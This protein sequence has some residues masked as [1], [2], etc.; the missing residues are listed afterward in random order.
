[1]TVVWLHCGSSCVSDQWLMLSILLRWWAIILPLRTDNLWPQKRLPYMDEWFKTYKNLSSVDER[2]KKCEKPCLWFNSFL[3][4]P[5]QPVFRRVHRFWCY[6]NVL[7][8]YLQCGLGKSVLQY[9]CF[10]KS[11]H[12]SVSLIFCDL[13]KCSLDNCCRSSVSALLCSFCPEF[14]VRN[15]REIILGMYSVIGWVVLIFVIRAFCDYCFIL[16]CW[17]HSL[18][19]LAWELCKRLTHSSFNKVILSGVAEFFSR[20]GFSKGQSVSGILSFSDLS[21]FFYISGS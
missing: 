17:E 7:S 11:C 12:Y 1:M 20:G 5:W 19:F 13:C 3:H 2:F 15:Y 9:L 18:L 14:P 16:S 21:N 8:L 4:M 6:K 10:R